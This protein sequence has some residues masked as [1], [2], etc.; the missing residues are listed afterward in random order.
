M[1]DLDLYAEQRELVGRYLRKRKYRLLKR[2]LKLGRKQALEY[3]HEYMRQLSI[4]ADRIDGQKII[5]IKR[6]ARSLVTDKLSSEPEII[7]SMSIK[8]LK[9]VAEHTD[10][11]LCAHPVDAAIIR[12]AMNQLRAASGCSRKITVIE[13]ESFGRGSIVVKADK[14]IIDAH[15]ETQLKRAIE[16]IDADEEMKWPD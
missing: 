2:G 6:L 13:D 3:R 14:S 8:L 11:E 15:I 1:N 12:D 16:L 9:K 7:I 4:I 5:L 10:V